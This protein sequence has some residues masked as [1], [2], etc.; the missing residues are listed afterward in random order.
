MWKGAF[1]SGNGGVGDTEADDFEKEQSHTARTASAPVTTAVETMRRA[2]SACGSPHCC[3][4][5]DDGAAPACAGRRRTYAPSSADCS[6][7]SR[8][9]KRSSWCVCSS[10]PASRS[11]TWSSATQPRRHAATSTSPL[12]A[13][14][15]QS[16]GRRRSRRGLPALDCA[17]L[18]QPP[19][20]CRLGGAGRA[21]PQHIIKR[22]RA[23]V[24][25]PNVC[26][27]LLWKTLKPERAARRRFAATC[28]LSTLAS[29]VLLHSTVSSASGCHWQRLRPGTPLHRDGQTGGGLRV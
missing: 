18:P 25:C 9:H 28:V 8:P 19:C 27:G 4:G 21:R 7:G 6:A 1:A 15:A 13:C 16:I 14:S 22:A 26:C 3:A 11:G 23:A 24:P 2:T 29:F 20:C 12:P 5:S 10:S 17:L